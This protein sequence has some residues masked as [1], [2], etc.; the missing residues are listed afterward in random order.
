RTEEPLSIGVEAHGVLELTGILGPLLLEDLR[1]V[2][3]KKIHL[4]IV[5]PSLVDYHHEHPVPTGIPG[6][7]AFRFTPRTRGPYRAFAD[8]QPL[9][10]GFQEYAKAAI[11][12]VSA[13]PAPVEK[14]YAANG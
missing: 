14:T 9:L 12:A 10:T 5:D 4:L 7:Y 8:V 6:E 13:D 2:H 1:E 3:T 11:G